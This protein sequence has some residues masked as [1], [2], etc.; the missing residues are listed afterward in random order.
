MTTLESLEAKVTPTP[1]PIRGAGDGMETEEPPKA[2]EVTSGIQPIKHHILQS[3]RKKAA[4]GESPGV[5]QLGKILTDKAVEVEAVRILVPKAAITHDIPHKNAKAK[6]LGHHRG[7]FLG[8][9]EG[10]VE[11]RKELS[12]VKSIL[13]KLKNS[14]RRL[15]QDKEGL[16]NQ[17]R[18]QTEVRTTDFM[19]TARYT[20]IFQ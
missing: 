19:S 4:P 3:P 2:V 20:W 12:E 6:S 16:S 5:L 18:V 7:E 15:L 1:A 8:Q 13:E 9:S 11:P 14:E 17:L 10:V